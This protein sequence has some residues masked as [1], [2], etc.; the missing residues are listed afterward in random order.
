MKRPHAKAQSRKGDEFL[1]VQDVARRLR[2]KRKTV[3]GM[4]GRGE[5][6]AV[7]IGGMWRVEERDFR[8][9]IDAAKNFYL[10]KRKKVR[11]S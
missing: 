1:T 6:V 8:S 10:N 11:Q 4:I 7:K 2:I 9:F 3:Y 5:L